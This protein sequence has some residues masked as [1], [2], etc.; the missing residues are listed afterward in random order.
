[1]K[2]RILMLSLALFLL[3]LTS[4]YARKD[5]EA[6]ICNPG[7]R[8]YRQDYGLPFVFAKKSISPSE[9]PAADSDFAMNGNQFVTLRSK[10]FLMSPSI[11]HEQYE[12]YIILFNLLVDCC[13]WAFIA[14]WIVNLT[15]R[16]PAH[17]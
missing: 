15:E 2:R 16:K 10:F 3:I 4:L 13:F 8:P 12:S 5:T 14:Y 11:Q 1:M 17:R 9:C 6:F 7:H